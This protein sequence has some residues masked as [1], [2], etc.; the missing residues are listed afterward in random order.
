ME[1]GRSTGGD[2]GAGAPFPG[3]VG[4]NDVSGMMA[5]VKRTPPHGA[6]RAPADTDA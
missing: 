4:R 3:R 6:R 2:A 1:F 5:H